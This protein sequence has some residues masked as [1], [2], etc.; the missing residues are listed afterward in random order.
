MRKLL[1]F[2]IDGTIL[3]EG[4]KRYIPDSAVE[5]V[6]KLQQNGHLCFINSGRSWSEINDNI[7]DLGFDGF[8]CG[9]GT[10]INYHGKPLLA[11]ELPMEL[12]DAIYAD[13][14]SYKLEWLLE[15]QHAIY[16]STLPYRTHIGDFYKEYHTLFPDHCV[17]YPPETR[18]LHF[19]KFCICVTPES[20]L[21]GFMDKY[22][23]SLTF[24]DRG[25]GFY[26]VVPV[27]HSKAT[28][29]QFLMDYFDIPLEDTIAIGDSNNDLPMLEFAGLSIGMQKS[30]ADV[31]STV[32]YVTDTVENDGIYKAM[33]HFHLI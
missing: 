19:D 16:Y 4:E 18:G 23:D 27:G 22:K 12:A 21:S 3:S 5:A 13:L 25:N 28:G 26:E 30:D 9:C 17:D 10:F 1:F 24:I 33:K 11:D 15:G 31:L 6:H 8:V 2:D 20:D 7:I 29:I 14:H 32:D